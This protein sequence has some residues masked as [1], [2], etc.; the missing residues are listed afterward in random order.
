MHTP[1]YLHMHCDSTVQRDVWVRC[2]GHE[3]NTL[4][5]TQHAATHCNTRNTLQHNATHCSVLQCIVDRAMCQRVPATHCDTLQ[6]VAVCCSVLQCVA[7]CCSVLQCLNVHHKSHGACISQSLQHWALQHMYQPVTATLQHCNTATLQHC[8]TATLQHMYQLVTATLQHGNTMQHTVTHCN[9]CHQRVISTRCNTLQHAAVH[10]LS[11]IW[12]L[13]KHYDSLQC[14]YRTSH[15]TIINESL[16]MHA[17]V[18][19]HTW[20]SQ[21]TS[22]IL[23]VRISVRMNHV[24]RHVTHVNSCPES[25]HARER[26]MSHIEWSH[27]HAHTNESCPC[28]TSCHTHAFM[29]W[30]TSRT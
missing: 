20:S 19:S 27:A 11:L 17:W 5:H 18:M 24:M 30:V 23:S 21:G 29:A 10:C 15:A 12:L 9:A 16:H 25:C 4:Q 6:R 2:N 8:N 13:N 1:S 3:C 28:H 7:V 26:V 14:T 22:P